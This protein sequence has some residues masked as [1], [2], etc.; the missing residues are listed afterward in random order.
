M[1]EDGELVSAA[2]ALL[3]GLGAAGESDGLAEVLGKL[4]GLAEWMGFVAL[5]EFKGVA[6]LEGMAGFVVG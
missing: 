2:E 4:A 5:T 3:A 1:E 6:E